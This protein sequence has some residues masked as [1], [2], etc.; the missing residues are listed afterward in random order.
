MEFE[1]KLKI[2]IDLL[3]EAIPYKYFVG[4]NSKQKDE[5]GEYE[6]LHGAPDAGRGIINRRLVIFENNKTENG[7]L[8]IVQVFIAFLGGQFAPP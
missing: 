4:I 6:F 2:D 7:M 1:C 5:K 8:Y 3:K